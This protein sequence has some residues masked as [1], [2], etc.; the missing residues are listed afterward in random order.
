MRPLLETP[1]VE[2]NNG[3]GRV[4][5]RFHRALFRALH[6]HEI[7]VTELLGDLPIPLDERGRLT[8]PVEWDPMRVLLRRLE[9]TLGGAE[10]L[11]QLGAW[12]VEGQIARS[13][14][15]LLGLCVS[16]TLL[17]RS[18]LVR[19]L[20]RAL[21]GV[22]IA[23]DSPRPKRLSVELA[24][25]PSLA[26]C[27][28]LLHLATG[29]LR[30]LPRLLELSDAV[31]ESRVDDGRAH[32]DLTLPASRTGVSRARRWLGAL[33]TPSAVLRR[34]E[35]HQLELQARHID[36]AKAHAAL[37]ASEQDQR[38]RVDAA[39]D[40]LCE[41][42]AAGRVVFASESTR[43]LMGYSPEQVTGS[44]Y[45]L[46]IP[47]TFQAA[48]REQFEAF[49]K[50]PLG[51]TLV[52]IPAELH[53]A[54][55]RRVRVEASLRSFAN[56]DGEWRAIV[57]L[58]EKPRHEKGPRSAAAASGHAS[59]AVARLRAGAST[60][61][62]LGPNHPL[63][64]SLPRLIALLEALARRDAGEGRALHD[65]LATEHRLRTGPSL[66]RSVARGHEATRRM[67]RL[68]EHVMNGID[69]ED[70]RWIEV[71]KLVDPLRDRLARRPEASGLALRIDLAGGPAELF[72]RESTLDT[73]VT[74]L[75]D[76]AVDRALRA[77]AGRPASTIRLTIAQEPDSP[78][79]GAA[80]RLEVRVEDVGG[81][82]RAEPDA[83]RRS[84]TAALLMRDAIR[85]S[86]GDD[87]L[88]EEGTDGELALALADDAA[89]ML[90]GELLPESNGDV[91]P[92]GGQPADANTASPARALRLPQP[93]AAA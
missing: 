70:D 90:G 66:D 48:A 83:R 81:P 31:V 73:C 88:R 92:T 60:F 39:V 61:A 35:D 37:L 87:D 46:W 57:N 75:F 15:S 38:V 32:W 84:P 47:T 16:P 14:R 69:E 45:R 72:G 28:A 50:A 65:P 8:G 77:P 29:M 6:A 9:N 59:Q 52:R 51:T 82:Q 64:R 7:P 44:F 55:G 11:E 4:S 78:D 33:F 18:V 74:G 43:D 25:P 71:Q 21:P 86:V 89:R 63:E 30:S 58:R 3:P 54:H 85:L 13:R 5:R 93:R 23:V 19:W 80:V 17:Y 12:I 53:A 40:M 20:I 10:G 79:G 26:P 62:D 76:W 67:T 2:A 36:L 41:F 56:P 68:V 91:A 27:P 34:L 24:L 42:D 22:A 49:R 1:I